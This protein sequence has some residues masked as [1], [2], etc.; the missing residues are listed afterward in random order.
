MAEEVEKKSQEAREWENKAR[1]ALRGKLYDEAITFFQEAIGLYSELEWQGQVGILKKEISRV[2]NLKAFFSETAA[3]KEEASK[4]KGR[5]SEE[6]KANN[7]L[8]KAKDAAFAGNTAEAIALY[9]DAKAIFEALDY[10]YQVKKIEWEITKLQ[11]ISQSSAQ[12]STVGGEPLSIAERRARRIQMAREEREREEDALIREREERAR[13]A[14]A[15]IRAKF[16]RARRSWDDSGQAESYQDA[17]QR[18]KMEKRERLRQ[19]QEKKRREEALQGEAEALMDEGKRLADEGDYAGAV[20]AYEVAAK[21]F[22]ELGWASQVEVL[23]RETHL[24]VKKEREET[25]RRKLEEE[26]KRAEEE[27]FKEKLQKMQKMSEIEQRRKRE[28]EALRAEEARKKKEEEFKKRQEK[29]LAEQ[30]ERERLE[31][32]R[33]RAQDPAY[34]ARLRKEKLAERTFTKAAK[35][36]K[37]GKVDEAV[38]RL[39]YV[40]ELYAELEF[41][42]DKVQRV[43]DEI[44]KIRR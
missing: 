31:E 19:L 14:Q 2:E 15:E 10:S 36:A 13:E 32:E 18:E 25:E 27:A 41:P 43:R 3:E 33:R 7:L 40:L 24:L 22:E 34:Q 29:L 8:K 12:P 35:L 39:E 23:K 28:E 20:R 5:Q 16:G 37:V 6:N 44:E 11:T 30:R 26:R 21:K 9:R 1:E 4:L 42:E 17:H 38:K